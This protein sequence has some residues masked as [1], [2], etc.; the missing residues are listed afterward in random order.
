MVFYSCTI[1]C[2]DLASKLGLEVLDIDRLHGH[3]GLGLLLAPH[4]HE[5]AD[6]QHDH[7]THATGNASDEADVGAAAAILVVVVGR[8]DPGVGGEA[9]VHLVRDLGGNEAV[10][11]RHGAEPL[12][13]DLGGGALLEDDEHSDNG[14]G[15][16]VRASGFEPA[17]GAAA[18]GHASLVDR[19][20]GDGDGLELAD[21]V[22]G[23]V[24]VERR[25]D[26]LLELRLGEAR[27]L[28]CELH[29]DVEGGDAVDGHVIGAGHH[30]ARRR[31]ERELAAADAVLALLERVGA[32][33]EEHAAADLVPGVSRDTL[34]E[35]DEREQEQ[36]LRDRERRP[37]AGL[38]RGPLIARVD[39]EGTLVTAIEFELA[40]D[41]TSVVDSELLGVVV[42]AQ[43]RDEEVRLLRIHLIIAD[44]VSNSAD[45]HGSGQGAGPGGESAVAHVTARDASVEREG[46]C[47]RARRVE[48]AAGEELGGGLEV[49]T[50]RGAVDREEEGAVEGI[51]IGVQSGGHGVVVCGFLE[52]VIHES[53]RV[54]RV[55]RGVG[56]VDCDIAVISHDVDGDHVLEL[57]RNIIAAI[58][59]QEIRVVAVK[60]QGHEAS[61][62]RIR[63]DLLHIS[64]IEGRGFDVSQDAETSELAGILGR[65]NNDVG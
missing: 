8:G 50:L 51:A 23:Q 7:S 4:E 6:G 57:Q 64:R 10:D 27:L 28:L 61:L 42:V 54:D 13:V 35:G 32:A 22:A 29:L 48:G 9:R 21:H 40:G 55:R 59:V 38:G 58:V 52:E 45:L 41:Y 16:A 36:L 5:G 65:A 47:V 17:E 25:Q 31:L 24:V 20:L 53:R 12:Q 19:H 1:G 2:L 15:V 34:V 62:D 56:F 11:A 30:A 49:R 37:S 18:A 14:R 26:G 63:I 43:D 39:P 33:L 60:H 3:H 44:A 46:A